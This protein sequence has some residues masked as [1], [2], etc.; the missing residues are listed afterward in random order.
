M[1]APFHGLDI[2]AVSPPQT[3]LENLSPTRIYI[4]ISNL[5]GEPLGHIGELLPD[6]RRIYHASS[7]VLGE[8]F[9]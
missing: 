2:P 7:E 6:V 4:D 8:G 9:Q 5:Q 3:L 1:V